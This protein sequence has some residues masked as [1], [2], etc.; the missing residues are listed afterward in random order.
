M[1]YLSQLNILIVSF[2]IIYRKQSYHNGSDR[3]N[4]IQHVLGLNYFM[5]SLRSLLKPNKTFKN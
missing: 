5:I 4:G 3:Q 2:T 1:S